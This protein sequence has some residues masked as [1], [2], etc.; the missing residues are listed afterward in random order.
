MLWCEIVLNLT[1]FQNTSATIDFY[2]LRYGNNLFKKKAQN[3][4]ESIP[5]GCQAPACRLYVLHNEFEHVW[6]SLYSEVQ[7]E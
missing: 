7:V 1:S 3:E 4:Q 2:L 5:V 6:G